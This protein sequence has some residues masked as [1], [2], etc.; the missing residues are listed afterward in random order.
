[1]IQQKGR[2]EKRS[3]EDLESMLLGLVGYKGRVHLSLSAPLT[4]QTSDLNEICDEID[5]RIVSNL[6][7][8]PTHSESAQRLSLTDQSFFGLASPN[9]ERPGRALETMLQDLESC[10]LQEKSFYLLQYANLL[11]NKRDLL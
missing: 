9:N 6:R 3:E 5:K 8:Y 2:Y 1:M 11:K 4:K 7:D 10:P